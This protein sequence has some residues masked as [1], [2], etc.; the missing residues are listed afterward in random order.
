MSSRVDRHGLS[1]ES[2]L[3]DFIS[4]EALPGTGVDPDGFWQGFAALVAD[5]TPRNAELLRFRDEL[6][7]KIDA[8]HIER[9]GSLIGLEDYKAFL[10]E[11]GYLVPEGEDFEITTANVDPEIAQIAG[12]QLVVPVLNAR[13][14]AQCRECAMG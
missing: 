10:F 6:Q 11:I 13:F 2:I 1:V 9:K 7:E 12:P 14:R 5:L 3:D 4:N 8:W